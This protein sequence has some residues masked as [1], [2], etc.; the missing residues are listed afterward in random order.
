MFIVFI[1]SLFSVPVFSTSYTVCAS[2]CD[3]T[4]IQGAIDSASTGDT[5]L[6]KDG[7]GLRSGGIRLP[8]PGRIRSGLFLVKINGN[9]KPKTKTSNSCMQ[10]IILMIQ[11]FVNRKKELEGENSAY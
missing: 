9:D 4:T 8:A 10:S 11:H 5:I 2:S 6:V 1:L 7:T 3:Y